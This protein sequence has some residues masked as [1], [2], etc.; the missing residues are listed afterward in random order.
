[1]T[2]RRHFDSS[3]VRTEEN[4]IIF[5]N[6]EILP[7][8]EDARVCFT[9]LTT[10]RHFNEIQR[11]ILL[12]IICENTAVDLRWLCEIHVGCLRN[13]LNCKL[14]VYRKQ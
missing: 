4:S 12:F 6:R 14:N 9:F 2:V 7:G 1:M 13:K 11:S 3:K 10:T 5:I 8:P